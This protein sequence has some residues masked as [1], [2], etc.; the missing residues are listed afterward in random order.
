MSLTTQQSYSWHKMITSN[1]SATSLQ[2]AKLLKRVLNLVASSS[3]LVHPIPTSGTPARMT[4]ERPLNL[5]QLVAE[6]NYCL[7]H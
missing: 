1:V 2:Y 5:V 7:E 6:F 3:V 4:D